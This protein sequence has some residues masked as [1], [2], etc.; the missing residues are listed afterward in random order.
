MVEKIEVRYPSS[1]IKTN[2]E[3]AT[4]VLNALKAR[5]DVPNDKVKVKVESGWITLT[6]EL[7]WNYQRE[8]CVPPGSPYFG[9]SAGT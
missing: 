3:I 7:N 4:E 2:A 5:W 9:D 1:F 8:A 6:G